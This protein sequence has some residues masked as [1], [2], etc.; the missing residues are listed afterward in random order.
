MKLVFVAPSAKHAAL[1][2]KN[3]NWLAWNQ[4]NVSEWGG[5]SICGLLVKYKA[6]L[7]IIISLKINLLMP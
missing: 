7:I 3:K 6:D 4:A 2:R 1:R 5:M